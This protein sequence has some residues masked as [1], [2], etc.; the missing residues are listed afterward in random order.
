[1]VRFWPKLMV[2]SWPKFGSPKNGHLRPE[3]NHQFVNFW[4]PTK[5]KT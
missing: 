3:P 2:R 4:A 1:M 5:N